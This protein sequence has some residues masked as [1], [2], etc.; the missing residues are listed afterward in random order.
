MSPTI[1]QDPY[2]GQG[3]RILPIGVRLTTSV[4]VAGVGDASGAGGGNEVIVPSK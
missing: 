2:V 3:V 1:R 4:V